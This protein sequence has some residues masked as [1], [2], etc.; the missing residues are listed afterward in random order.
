VNRYLARIPVFRDLSLNTFTFAKPFEN[1][2]PEE[3]AGKYSVS[4]V[5]PAMNE[6]GNIEDAILR[7]PPLGKWTEIIFIEGGSSDD[8]WE[9][10]NEMAVKYKDQYRIKIG[11]QDGTGKGDAV[12]KGYGMAEGDILMILDA[13][14]TVPPEDLPKFYYA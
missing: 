10:I 8:T 7:L 3:V 6:S 11:Q 1:K 14:L 4:V 12:R 5:I 2:T 9:K 13:D